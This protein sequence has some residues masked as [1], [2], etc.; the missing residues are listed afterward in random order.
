MR[1]RSRLRAALW[2]LLGRS[3]MYGVEIQVSGE[4]YLGAYPSRPL[5]PF[6]LLV[7]ESS[8]KLRS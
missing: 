3:V 5:K 6:K 4:I 7:T 1:L 2:V 8:I